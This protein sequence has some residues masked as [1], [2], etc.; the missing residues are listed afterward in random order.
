MF[1]E[2]TTGK[3]FNGCVQKALIGSSLFRLP[4]DK[5]G[6]GYIFPE[7]ARRAYF[8]AVYLEKLVGSLVWEPTNICMCAC[9]SSSRR[10]AEDSEVDST[11]RAASGAHTCPFYI[12]RGTLSCR[13]LAQESSREQCSTISSYDF[14]GYLL[15]NSGLAR[16]LREV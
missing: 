2:N 15:A 7:A 10:L 5:I 14:A 9:S 8:A 11:C 6:A 1:P 4:R 12:S 16:F 13:P 3:T